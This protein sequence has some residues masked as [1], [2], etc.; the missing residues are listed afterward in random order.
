MDW[1]AQRILKELCDEETQKQVLETVWLSPLLMDVATQINRMI[2]ARLKTR[3]STIAKWSSVDKARL[4]H[5]HRGMEMD[6]SGLTVILSEFLR[7]NRNEMI[8][9]FMDMCGI[10]NEEGA[11]E[12]VVAPTPEKIGRASCRERV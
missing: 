2:A 10:E 12:G 5:K 7:L 1:T 8:Q 9:K 4:M 11:Y 6:E 3:P